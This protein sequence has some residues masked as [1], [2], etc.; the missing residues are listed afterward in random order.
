MVTRILF[1]PRRDLPDGTTA[2][3][4]VI[5]TATPTGISEAGA[6]VVL[7]TSL[8][9]TVNTSA[10]LVQLVPSSAS[11]KWRLTVWDSVTQA[12]LQTRTVLVPDQASVTWQ[13]LVDVDP[14]S[15]GDTTSHARN[16]DATF[17][18]MLT[19]IEQAVNAGLD[20]VNEWTPNTA[21]T[22]GT[23]VLNPSA[24]LV[25]ANTG[26]TSGS[27]YN[28]ANWT[29]LTLNLAGVQA[30]IAA[31]AATDSTTS[32]TLWKPSTAYSAGQYV[33]NPSG[34]IA[35]V[36]TTH[37]STTTYDATKFTVP[38][39][40][41]GGLSIVDNLDSTATLTATGSTTITDNGDGTASIAA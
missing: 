26:F 32:V 20:A 40:S 31:Q 9:F 19:L 17:A 21:Y 41:G 37:T 27:S 2:S 11:W 16:W 7:P 5:V 12:I 22:S 38:G 23:V 25:Q 33:I 34:Q 24:Q 30:L 15:L 36:T 28:P 13:A 4:P 10:D 39:G 29:I 18:Q 3:N 35:L 6:V 1:D 14:S 8:S